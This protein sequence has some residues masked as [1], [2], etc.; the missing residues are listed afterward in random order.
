[1]YVWADA[2]CTLLAFIVVFFPSAQATSH[3][4]EDDLTDSTETK[5]NISGAQGTFRISNAKGLE[6]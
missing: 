3:S 6:C 5:Q 4:A 2:Q 1:M